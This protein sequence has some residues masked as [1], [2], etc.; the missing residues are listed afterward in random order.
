MRHLLAVT[1]KSPD[2]AAVTALGALA[3]FICCV[4]LP[5]TQ[6]SIHR[7]VSVQTVCGHA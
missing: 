1:L 5:S 4:R 7:N 3:S 6:R 2:P